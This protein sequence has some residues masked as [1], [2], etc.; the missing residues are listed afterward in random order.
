MRAENTDNNFTTGF[1]N[2]GSPSLTLK[3]ILLQMVLSILFAGHVFA[4][5]G[6]TAE[7]STKAW[8]KMPKSKGIQEGEKKIRITQSFQLWNIHTIESVGNQASERKNDLYIRRGRIGV[9]GTVVSNLSFN[10]IFAYDGIGRNKNTAGRGKPNPDDNREFFLFEAQAMWKY[11]S[12]LNI[13]AGYFRPQVGREQMTAPFRTTSFEFSM[14]NFQPR[15]HLVGRGSGREVGVNV[16][17]LYK[18]S[19]WS[20][21]YNIG[22]F[23]ISSKKLVGEGA[24]SLPML[25]SRLALSLGDPEMEKYGL[26]IKQ[27]YYGQ[28]KGITFAL[29]GSYLGETELLESNSVY[30]GD[31]LANFGPVDFVFEYDWLFRASI[32]EQENTDLNEQIIVPTT[33][34][35]YTYKLAYNFLLKNG[36]VLQA[37]AMYSGQLAND[38]GDTAGFNTLTGASDHQVYE[39]G[40]NYLLDKDNLKLNMHYVWGERTDKMPGH[41][42]AFFGTGFQYLF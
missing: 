30:G 29:N 39:V 19:G 24:S 25:T 26:G 6:V 40:L 2:V 13:T 1:A 3:T 12:L 17:G 32:L 5:D 35:V 4:Q 42:Y 34:Q 10:L 8:K 27:S 38:Y 7:D 41:L 16:G 15:A 37:A 14:S 23:D 21:N 33:D 20:L 28:R 18:T 11:H 9:N 31:V 36:K 22:L